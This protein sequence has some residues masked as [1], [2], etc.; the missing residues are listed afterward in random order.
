MV[1]LVRITN[2][3][4][5]SPTLPANQLS[6]PPGLIY[7]SHPL[8][9]LDLPMVSSGDSVPDELGEDKLQSPDAGRNALQHSDSKFPSSQSDQGGETPSIKAEKDLLSQSEKLGNAPSIMTKMTSLTP[10]PLPGMEGSSTV[11]REKPTGDGYNWRKYGQKLVKGN[12][13][14]RSYYRCTHPK[15]LVKKQLEHSHD[16]RMVDIVYFGHHDHPKSLNLPLAVDFGVSV[17]EER[18][19]N[20]SAIVVKDK[21]LDAQAP[22]HIEPTGG[23]QPLA[24]AVIEDAK[25]ASSKSNRIRNVADSDDDHLISKRRKKE[26]SNAVA[27]PVEKPASE[28]HTVIKTL[29]EVD[30]VNDGYRWRKYG[31]KLVKGNPN[32]RSYYRCSTPGCPVKKHVERASHDAKLVIT[33]YE[34][35][36]D[37]DLPP[38]RTVITTYQGVNVHSGSHYDKPSTKVEESQAVC[39][40]IIVHPNF[41]VENKSSEQ[42]NGESRTKSEGSDTVCV[43]MMNTPILCLE[44]GSNEQQSGKL[45]PSKE[46]DAVHHCTI[47][48]ST[49]S[50]QSTINKQQ[51]SKSETKSEADAV[52]IDKMVHTT[53]HSDCNFDEQ[54]LPSTEPVQS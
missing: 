47:V 27:S 54:R 16:G 30:I 14:I 20:S 7:A 2:L 41:K 39:L 45:D 44:S 50:S 3:K 37:H 15:C 18:P 12:E 43:G 35:R 13:F 51:S 19:D 32:P 29:S 8:F 34:G 31:Q 11:V 21:S 40:D 1:F 38:S 48:H 49:S 46:N 33:T 26:N 42:L 6:L 25:S 24:S 23:S 53:P 28:S 36:H 5:S 9:H 22:Q 17:V 10:S 52:C 4:R